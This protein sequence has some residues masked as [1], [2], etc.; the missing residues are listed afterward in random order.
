MHRLR[1]FIGLLGVGAGLGLATLAVDAG[2]QSVVNDGYG[3]YLLV[4]AGPFQMGDST[5]EGH[6]RERPLHAVT[7]DAFYVGKYEIMGDAELTGSAF[8]V[9]TA[10][11]YM[12]VVTP[13]YQNVDHLQDPVF[14]GA[15]ARTRWIWR[16]TRAFNRRL[17]QLARFRRRAGVYGRRNSGWRGLSD[18]PG[19]RLGGLPMLGRG[20]A[21]W[22]RAEAGYLRHRLR[23]GRLDLSH[24]VPEAAAPALGTP[25]G[26][27]T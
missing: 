23:H 10:L 11:Y 8:M 19:L 15:D 14:G 25:A 13:I 17:V 26:A 4:P 27:P 1:S 2:Q 24:P 21:I 7:V 16:A 22:L 6:S 18:P 9:D 3:D 20:L 5:G 12:G